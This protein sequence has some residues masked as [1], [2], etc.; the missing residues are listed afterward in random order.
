MII[1]FSL[2]DPEPTVQKS[3]YCY[4]CFTGEGKT[5]GKKQDLLRHLRLVLCREL[6]GQPGRGCRTTLCAIAA[7]REGGTTECHL[8]GPVQSTA[9]LDPRV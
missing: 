7:P 1:G 2:T 4:C 3:K 6:M 8:L 5:G 9:S